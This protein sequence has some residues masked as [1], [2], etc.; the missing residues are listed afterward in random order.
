[1]SGRPMCCELLVWCRLILR[2]LI[3]IMAASWKPSQTAYTHTQEF[4][5]ERPYLIIL[6][7]RF[8]DGSL[9]RHVERPHIVSRCPVYR[10][11]LALILQKISIAH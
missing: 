4:F 7:F 6:Q 5:T 2:Q 9:Q 11:A 10:C 8:V 3:R 1:M